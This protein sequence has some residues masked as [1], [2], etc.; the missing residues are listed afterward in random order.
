MHAPYARALWVLAHSSLHIMLR[1]MIACMSASLRGRL[2][3]VAH[4]TRD[5]SYP[6]NQTTQ[7]PTRPQG[8]SIVTP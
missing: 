3:T 4:T 2:A 6:Q 1:E 7:L 5:F 8:W